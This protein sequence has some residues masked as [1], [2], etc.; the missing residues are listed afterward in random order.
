MEE[1]IKNKSKVQ[2]MEVPEEQWFSRLNSRIVHR[3]GRVVYESDTRKR[4]LAKIPLKANRPVD[5]CAIEVEKHCKL[6]I[7]YSFGVFG[8]VPRKGK[9]EEKIRA[10]RTIVKFGSNLG[11]NKKDRRPQAQDV[12][13]SKTTF[14]FRISKMQPAA[15]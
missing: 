14:F 2:Y 13:K 6:E 5:W 3:R 1:N 10:C 12:H 8:G 4:H 7:F 15:P 9:K 11:L